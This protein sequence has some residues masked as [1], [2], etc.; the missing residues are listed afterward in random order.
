MQEQEIIHSLYGN[1]KIPLDDCFFLNGQ[2]LITTDSL[3][4]NTHFHMDWSSPADIAIK[5]VEVNI[6]DIAASGGVPTNAFLNLGLSEKSGEKKWV[7]QFIRA[8][9]DSLSR[10]GI[11][12][13]GGDTFRSESSIFTLTLIGKA[14]KPIT[15]SGGKVGDYL[16]LTGD[17][18]LSTIGYKI[19]KNDLQVEEK[20]RRKA[21]KKHLRPKSQLDLA[22]EIFTKIRVSCAMDITD[23]MI[24]DSEKLAIA[25]GISLEIDIDLIPNQKKYL[26]FISET[27]LLNSGEELEILFLSPK[28]IEP[29][30]FKGKV[31]KIG[32]ARKGK[33]AV[34][35]LKNGKIFIP[36]NSGFVH[37]H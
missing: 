7:L 6:S 10:Y 25:S 31:R 4:E 9:R 8:F 26:Q 36:E 5:L 28:K 37:F 3:A 35:F 14:K 30:Q 32:W 34:R 12:L 13:S 29:D 2:Y 18:G 19:L 16:Y 33:P 20:L 23:G 11:N 27:E 17:I 22:S 24:Q 15:R 21:L 1:H